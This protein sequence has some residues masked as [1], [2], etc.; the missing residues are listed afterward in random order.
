MRGK[1][2]AKHKMENKAR[3]RDTWVVFF[4]NARS[5]VFS[6]SRL[7]SHLQIHFIS[8]A[9]CCAMLY[10]YTSHRTALISRL[11]S[12][13]ITQNTDDSGKDSDDD[14]DRLYGA[15][16]VEYDCTHPE[17]SITTLNKLCVILCMFRSIWCVFFL[18]RLFH[19]I[20]QIAL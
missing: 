15:K 6:R 18:F 13:S 7:L 8:C 12:D 14:D 17:K 11:Y 4:F 20:I 5:R 1:E 10:R 19:G 9:L 3:I 16:S 2:R